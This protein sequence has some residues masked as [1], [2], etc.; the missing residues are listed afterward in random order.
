MNYI[1][2][3]VMTGKEVTIKFL[4]PESEKSIVFVGEQ[5]ALSL[6]D[7]LSVT[8]Y[9]LTNVSPSLIETLKK[10]WGI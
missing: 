10:D 7:F 2:S 1:V 9:I 5:I 3:D 4:N 8:Q 6:K